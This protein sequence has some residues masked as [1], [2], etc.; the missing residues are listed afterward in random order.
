M[1]DC[2]TGNNTRAKQ[3][4]EML[5]LERAAETTV[6]V[7]LS[8][9]QL[10]KP[11]VIEKLQKIFEGF[12]QTEAEPLFIIMGSFISKPISRTVYGR[13]AIKAA[14]SSLAD[15]IE[16]CPR[17]SKEGKF[18]LIPGLFPLQLRLFAYRSSVIG[19]FDAG[20]SVAYPRRAI[21]SDLTE[22]IRSR[23][24]HVTFAS[25]P[26]R[27][28]FY[29]QEIVL[30]REDLLKKMQRHLALPLLLPKS[31]GTEEELQEESGV[32]VDKP[33]TAA[34]VPDI[35]AQL[36]E[37]IMDQ[38]HLFPLPARAKP[39]FWDLD[40]TMRLFPLPHLLVLADHAEKYEYTY[41]GC[42]TVNP[43]KTLNIIKLY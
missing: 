6:M 36:V 25:N 18:L 17:L 20:S 34:A 38:S 37:S 22:G 11:L 35:T 40:Y 4:A 21:P 15:I 27:I 1:N 7:I 9:V 30:F 43:G 10:D 29:T 33:A 19:P 2:C 26:C 14:F 41:Q 24:P 28:R 23:I 13:A 39:V 32:G 3:Q 8:D 16:K 5:E 42:N 12:E 31:S